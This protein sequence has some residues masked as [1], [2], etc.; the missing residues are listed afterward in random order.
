[1]IFLVH[2]PEFCNLS[3]EFFI[4]SSCPLNSCIS[5]LL[6][7]SEADGS[8]VGFSKE[9]RPVSNKLSQ[10][11]LSLNQSYTCPF[12]LSFNILVAWVAARSPATSMSCSF[13]RVPV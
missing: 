2:T 11:V 7:S 4:S 10:L 1:M 13:V 12:F 9:I 6:L 5:L 8:V 3:P